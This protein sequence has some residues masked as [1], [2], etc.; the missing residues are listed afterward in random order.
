MLGSHNLIPKNLIK[1]NHINESSSSK[2][3]Y[4]YSSSKSNKHKGK[5]L[6]AI[7]DFDSSRWILD[8]RAS[9]NMALL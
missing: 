4:Y 3:S 9:H 1:N 8:S 6:I 5:E 2:G 7:S